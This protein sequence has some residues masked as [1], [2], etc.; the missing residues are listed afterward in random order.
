MERVCVVGCVARVARAK[1][2]TFPASALICFGCAVGWWGVE[3]RY[4]AMWNY[5]RVLEAP[6]PRDFWP[7]V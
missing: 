6:L 5:I 2:F 7:C 3:D 1:S 4:E